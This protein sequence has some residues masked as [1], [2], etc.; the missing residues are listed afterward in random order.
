[1]SKNSSTRQAGGPG[2]LKWPRVGPITACAAAVL[3]ELRGGPLGVIDGPGGGGGRV[4]KSPRV[5]CCRAGRAVLPSSKDSMLL[6]RSPF[7]EV[8]APG[9][10]SWAGLCHACGS[11]GPRGRRS[12]SNL[13]PAASTNRVKFRELPSP[14]PRLGGGPLGFSRN[15]SPRFGGALLWSAASV[16]TRSFVLGRRTF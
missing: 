12:S 9:V 2:G 16:G 3:S 6:G 4:V 13:G 5:R 15:P 10:G 14:S 1:M 7:S 11:S 8:V